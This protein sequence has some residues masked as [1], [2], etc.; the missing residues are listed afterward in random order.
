MKVVMAATLTAGQEVGLEGG[1]EKRERGTGVEGFMGLQGEKEEEEAGSR[2]RGR[3]GVN[4]PDDRPPRVLYGH[5][6]R[7]VTGRRGVCDVTGDKGTPM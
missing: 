7:D 3:T 6:L 4:K 2:V 5:S 1:G